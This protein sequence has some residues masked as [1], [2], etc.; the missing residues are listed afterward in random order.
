MKGDLVN[1]MLNG[2]EKQIKLADINMH[3]FKRS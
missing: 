3:V 2:P 1:E